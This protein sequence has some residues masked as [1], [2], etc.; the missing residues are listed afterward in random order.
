MSVLQ[1]ISQHVR[2][3][4]PLEQTVLDKHATQVMKELREV[5]NESGVQTV[6]LQYLEPLL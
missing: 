4:E 3:I 6:L 1:G 5:K 2:N